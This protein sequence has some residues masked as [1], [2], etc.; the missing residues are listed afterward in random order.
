MSTEKIYRVYIGN[1]TYK[2]ILLRKVSWSNC[3]Y[4][5]TKLYFKP[6]FHGLNYWFWNI[7][8]IF[9]GFSKWNG[10]LSFRLFNSF[11]AFAVEIIVMCFY[12]CAAQGIE[13]NTLIIS[14]VTKIAAKKENKANSN[15]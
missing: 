15:R 8:L 1:P 7:N 2:R 13:P 4:K 11:C 9:I 5:N 6:N 14:G 12:V 10:Q 3:H